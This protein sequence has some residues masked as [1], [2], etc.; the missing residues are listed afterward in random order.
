LFLQR[1][2][3]TFPAGFPGIGLLLLRLGA[4]IPLTYLALEDLLAAPD[5]LKAALSV[6]KGVAG[7][8]LLSGLWTPPAAGVVVLAELLTFFSQ[9]LAKHVCPFEHIFLAVLGSALALLGPGAWSVDAR[10]FGRKLFVARQRPTQRP[11]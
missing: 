6:A 7:V 8:L 3:S 4:G 9:F 10:R 2:F 11:L 1:L 5:L